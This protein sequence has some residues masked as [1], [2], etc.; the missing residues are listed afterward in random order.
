[1]SLLHLKARGGGWGS[2]GA[3][4]GVAVRDGKGTKHCLLS[5][6]RLATGL[7]SELEPRSWEE[8]SPAEEQCCWDWVLVFWRTFG[9]NLVV[10]IGFA[11]R[12]RNP[13]YV[14]SRQCAS[15]D[16]WRIGAIKAGVVAA[17]LA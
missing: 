2:F 6:S 12:G 7:G 14:R 13:R 11:S 5:A 17:P 8:S 16:V 9:R 4:A 1:M 15:L 10:V 3:G